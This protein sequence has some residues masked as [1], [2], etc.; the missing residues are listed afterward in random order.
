MMTEALS[1]DGEPGDIR[2]DAFHGT[3]REN[4]LKIKQQGFLPRLGIAGVGC[5]F[6]LGDDASARVFA[7]ERAGGD[8]E[9]AVVIRAEVHLGTTLDLSL[10]TETLE[11]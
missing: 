9:Q 7:L 1:Y 3:R 5:Y 2:D 11:G 8:P 10:P 6:D 4:A